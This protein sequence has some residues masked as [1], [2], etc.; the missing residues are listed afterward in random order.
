M[1]GGLRCLLDG[2]VFREPE[3]VVFG[4]IN[5]DFGD[6]GLILLSFAEFV[7]L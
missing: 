3:E 4:C 7:R 1:A 2:H 6:Q 5:T